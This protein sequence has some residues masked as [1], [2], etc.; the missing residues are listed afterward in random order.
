MRYRQFCP[1]AKAAELLGERWTFLIIR[2]LLM[3]GTRFSE[4]QS[5]LAQ[6]SP[7]LLTKRLNELRENGLVLR[8]KLHGK[9][10]YEYVLTQAGKE[11]MPVLEQLGNWGMRWARDQMDYS[12][13]DVELLMIYLQRSIKTDQ[14][15][16]SETVIK[17]HFTNL[18]K[19]GSWWIVVQGDSVE[20]CLQDP[21]REVDVYFTSDLQTMVD[22]WM[23]DLTLK[24]ACADG[25][26]KLVGEQHLTNRVHNWLAPSIFA[27]VPR[28]TPVTLTGV[29][30]AS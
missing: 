20:L 18:P 28:W 21:G 16:G 26:M 8:R 24:A 7:S 3:G 27:D 12:D 22:Y 10:G 14:L 30:R 4:L 9:R 25:R 11:L 2:E 5:G 17:F 6:I 15:P 19:L 29:A 23:G 13:Y 1:V